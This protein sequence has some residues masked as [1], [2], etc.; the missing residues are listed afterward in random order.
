MANNNSARVNVD[1]GFTQALQN[2]APYPI[3]AT[4]SPTLADRAPLGAIWVNRTLNV[5]FIA[6]SANNTGTIW[7]GASGAATTPATLAVTTTATIGTTLQVGTDLTVLGT[8]TVTGASAL[9]GGLTVAGATVLNGG[10]VGIG[11][12]ANAN[13]ISIST[14]AVARTTNIGVAGANVQTISIGGTGANVI[15][16]GNTQTAGSVAIG[17]AMTTGTISIGGTGLQTG[18]VSLAP[19]T[20]AQI[21]NIGTGGTGVK[22]IN[23]GTG[24]VAN[25]LTIGAVTGAARTTIQGGTVGIILSAGGAVAV[26]PAVDTQA[27]P[28]AA[29]TQNFNVIRVI[30]TGFTTAQAASQSWTITSNKILV[31]SGIFVTVASLNASGNGAFMTINGVRQAAGSIVI[32]TTNNGAGA[33]GG[34]DNVLVTVWIVS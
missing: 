7:T 8:A 26:D 23:I 11:T 12:D 29:S 27:S 16:I 5:V 15:A 30:F 10:T 32:S 24:A 2:V 17:T 25:L 34:G 1:Y 6:T 4:R 19:G 31:T 18:T 9:N 33:L 3:S 21:V 20:G 13:T 22:T 28:T 14:G